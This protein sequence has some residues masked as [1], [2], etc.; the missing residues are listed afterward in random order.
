MAVAVDGAFWYSV[1]SRSKEEVRRLLLVAMV[2]TVGAVSLALFSPIRAQRGLALV[3]IIGI[4]LDWFVTRYVLERSYLL[5][6]RAP[7][8]SP[9][10]ASPL[11]FSPIL[12]LAG[13]LDPLGGGGRHVTSRC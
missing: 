7:P 2:T 12:V 10:K 6:R 5:I 11:V 8:R 1:S 13:G 9:A 4:L 3:M